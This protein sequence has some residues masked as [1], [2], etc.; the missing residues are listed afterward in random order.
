MIYYIV[1]IFII[2]FG[3]YIFIKLSWKKKLTSEKVKYFKDIIRKTN[4]L[5]SEKEK[6]VNFDKIYHKILSEAWYGWTFWEILKKKPKEIKNINNIWELHK[7][8]NKL[9]HDFEHFDEKLLIKK[10]NDYLLELSK[11]IDYVS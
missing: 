2:I 3:I 6:L 4:N 1:W 8:R 11:L 7:I 10:N 9:V 5:P